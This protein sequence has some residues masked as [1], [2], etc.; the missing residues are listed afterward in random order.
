[1]L[2]LRPAYAAVPLFIATCLAAVLSACGGGGGGGSGGGGNTTPPVTS[3]ALNFTPATV[4][5]SVTAGTSQTLSVAAAVVRPGDFSNATAI[6]ALLTDTT[7]VILPSAQV[8]RDSDTQY[9]ATLQTAPTL[10]AG[11]Y[12]G[13]FSVKLCRDNACA[14]QFPGSPMSL[15]YDITVVPAGQTTLTAVPTMPLTASVQSGGA[16]PA[17]VTVAITSGG[18]SWTASNG[19]ASWLKLSATSGSGDGSLTV[20]YDAS[21]LAQGDYS[22]TLTIASDTQNVV[23]PVALTVLPPGLVLGSSSVTFNAINGAP[24]PSQIIS[25]D[26][27]N[28]IST[29]FTAAS[30]A[31]WLTVSPTSGATPATTI[32]S[33]DPTVG[34][35]ISGSYSGAVTLTASN[36]TARTLPVTLNLTP[37]KLQTSV[38]SLAFG[39]PYGRDFS[40]SQS[41]TLNLN[42]STNSWPW[43]LDTLPSW[44]GANV[45]GGS[46][47][48]AGTTLTF[49]ALP[50]NTGLGANS[51][52]VTATGKVNGDSVTTQLLFSIN[53]D[54]HKLLPSEVAV[55]LI[56]VPGW[57]R[58]TRTITVADN[59]GSFGGMSATSDQS[60][61]VVA[62][63]GNKLTLTADPS[64]LTDDSLNTATITVTA[65]DNDVTALERIRVSLWRGAAKPA[66][67]TTAALPY[68]NLVA[69]P[70]RPYVYA[71]NGGAY[72]DIYNVYTGR[73]EGTLTGFS[74]SLGDM[75]VTPNGDSLYVVDINNSRVTIVNLATRSISAQLPLAVAGTSNTRIRLIRPNG[76]E[77][78]LL[79]DGQVY[80]TLDTK[81]LNDLPLSGGGVMA[82][83]A[84]GKRLVQQSETSS[85]KHTSVNLD[86]ATFGGG[87][88]FAA[89]VNAASHASP[90]T[91]GQDV[92]ISADATRIYSAAS[93]PKSCAIMNT[94]DL[95]ILGY[96]AIGDAAPNNI[97]VSVDGRIFCGGATRSG[98]SDIYMYDSAGSKILQQ[99]KLSTTGKQLLPRQMVLSGEGWV[100][101]AI[102]DDG[103]VTF[104]AIGP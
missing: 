74:S 83:S 70:L 84:D 67:A 35:L 100:L 103:T 75:A 34:K 29:G 4:T 82:I 39:G 21:G 50:A 87:T 16:A 38:A 97:K 22:S 85:I 52:M 8:V 76:V 55:P 37:A 99:Y 20:S 54:A 93:A 44:L 33:V 96:M 101:S 63:S 41:L 90:G 46:V 104:L 94:S 27:D 30:N 45:T 36:Q 25:L 68:T 40:S 18:R 7:G 5:A 48:Q 66:A 3:P 57:S 11:N 77:L 53:K 98:N 65:S 95:G 72:I 102:T 6:F 49:K 42:T 79:S 60:W 73:K 86:Y 15:P 47:N 17:S 28:K 58:L 23:L 56:S 91:Q 71:H 51:A 32:L 1:M 26:T 69:D 92:A 81:R 59:Y 31:A 62:V 78:L 14:S 13:S 2:R 9:H 43:Q 24:V 19:G 61:L 10:A 80:L 12:K 89:K 88:L 64:Q